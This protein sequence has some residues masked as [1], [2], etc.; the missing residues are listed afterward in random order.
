[1]KLD[2]KPLAQQPGEVLPFE[3]C[4]DLSDTEWNGARPFDA[5]DCAA[6]IG[7]PSGGVVFSGAWFSLG[8]AKNDLI[9]RTGYGMIKIEHIFG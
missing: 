2:L 7:L 6:G 5:P 9:I 3:L 4:V 8:G 1:M